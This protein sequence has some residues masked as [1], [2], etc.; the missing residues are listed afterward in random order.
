M[1]VG[2][3]TTDDATKGS[4]GVIL[5]TSDILLQTASASATPSRVTRM[6]I[7]SN[8]NVGIG[9]P[10]P[11]GMLQ[12]GSTG[13][14]SD[15]QIV[16]AKK[17]GSPNRKFRI[18]LDDNF[19]LS[20]GDFG[21]NSS[22]VYVPQITLNYS[23]GN[24]LIGTATSNAALLEVKQPTLAIGSIFQ[25]WAPGVAGA[26]FRVISTTGQPYMQ[27]DFNNGAV[28]VGGFSTG[29]SVSLRIMGNSN[30]QVG[31]FNHDGQLYMP[32]LDTSTGTDLVLTSGGFIN[33]KS[34]SIRYKENIT[35]I[36]IGLDFI[37][38]LNPVK[39]NM[40]SDGLAQV[41]FVAEEFP[42]ERLVSFS[43]IDVE[44]DSKGLQRESVNYA[45]IV[46]PLVKAIQEQQSTI[47]SQSQKIAILESC[48]GIM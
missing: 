14:D 25:A 26:N 33:K 31:H 44:D 4:T 10:T 37:M 24:V 18:G 23:N 40:K 3:H 13:T 2:S 15:G 8:G 17:N 34:S 29:A 48:L 20:I 38:S 43:Q 28:Q 12:V 1:F 19:N 5:S 16:I 45:Q 7:L 22:D 6:A 39:F 11:T 32:F 47:C 36:D 41:G 42:D 27:Y 46:A 30:A 35:P 21:N 9:T